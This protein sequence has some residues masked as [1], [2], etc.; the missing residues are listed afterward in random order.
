MCGALLCL[1]IQL[2]SPPSLVTNIQACDP[3]ARTPSAFKPPSNITHL[4]INL[5]EI[6]TPSRYPIASVPSSSP[7]VLKIHHFR[8]K[9]SGEAQLNHLGN[10]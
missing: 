9:H 3:S 7:I 1:N 4:H 5:S 10:L 6:K 2:W 8:L